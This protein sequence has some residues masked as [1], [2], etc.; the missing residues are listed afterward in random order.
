[1]I[2]KLFNLFYLVAVGI[3]IIG[4]CYVIWGGIKEYF[5][6]RNEKD[7]WN[8]N[9][10]GL[11]KYNRMKTFCYF[12]INEINERKSLIKRG[13]NV[14]ED[15]ERLKRFRETLIYFDK[16][17]NMRKYFVE[18]GYIYSNF[19]DNIKEMK[20]LEKELLDDKTYDELNDFNL[21]VGKCD[22]NINHI[23]DCIKKGKKYKLYE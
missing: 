12:I 6:K 2:E 15:E 10:G 21:V 14:Y 11:R 19:V 9:Y 18:E 20:L 17:E 22:I 8:T 13:L 3:I 5:D 7:L 23:N 1:M 4:F 16:L